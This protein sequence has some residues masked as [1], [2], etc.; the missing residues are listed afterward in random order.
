MSTFLGD[1]PSVTVYLKMCVFL[2][3]WPLRKSMAN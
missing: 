2:I 1:N 3:G